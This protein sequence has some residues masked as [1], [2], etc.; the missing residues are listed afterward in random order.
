M[1]RSIGYVISGVGIVILAMSVD[2]IYK[3]LKFIQGISSDVLMIVGVILA[4]VGIALSGFRGGK[5]KGR[6]V[7]I[8]QGKNLIGYRRVK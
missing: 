1:D 3:N 2:V 4:I 7:P 6:E 5:G 8:Y